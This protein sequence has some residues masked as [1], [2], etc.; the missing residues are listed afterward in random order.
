[1]HMNKSLL[2]TLAMLLTAA[3]GAWADAGYTG[4]K[5]TFTRADAGSGTATDAVSD[6]TVNVTDKD[7]NAIAGVSATLASTTITQL[8]TG[9][10]AALSRTSNA[11]LAPNAGYANN[12]NSTIEYTFCVT[13]LSTEFTYNYAALDVY[14]LTSGGAAQGNTGNTVREWTFDVLTGSTS[15]GVSSFVSQAGN[16]ICTVTNSDG[17]LYHKTWEMAAS[18]ENATAT[19]YIKV[20]LKKTDSNGCYAGLGSVQL[21]Y[22][23]PAVVISDLNNLS[24]AKSYSLS[25]PRGTLGVNGSTFVSTAKDFTASEFA[26]VSYGGAYY[27]YSVAAKKFVT[28]EGALAYTVT[29]SSALT[30]EDLGSSN[31]KLKLG[32]SNYINVS[33]G[34]DAGLVVDAHSTTDEGNTFTITEASDFDATDAL[35]AL[36]WVEYDEENAAGEIAY[37]AGLGTYTKTNG[38]AYASEWVSNITA[39]QLTLLTDVN[40]IVIADGGLHTQTYKLS[41]PAGYRITGYSFTATPS[42][43]TTGMS[44]TPAGSSA[45][46][47]PAGGTAVDVTGLNAQTT[48]FD[49]SG[50]YVRVSNFKVTYTIATIAYITDLASL[51]NGKAYIVTNA[52][53]A[54]QVASASATAFS[55]NASVNPKTDRGNTALQIAIIKQGE[56]YYLYSVNAGKYLTAANSLYASPLDSVTI[57]EAT[58]TGAPD[59]HKWFFSFDSSHNINVNS[60]PDFGTGTWSTKDA[61]NVCAII[62]AADFDN[63]AALAAFTNYGQRVAD[64]ATYK[65]YMTDF[66]HSYQ[67]EIGYP[68]TTSTGYTN[69]AS[70]LTEAS[71]FTEDDYNNLPTYYAA[72]LAETDINTPSAGFYRIYHAVTSGGTKKYLTDTGSA[73]VMPRN[74]YSIGMEALWLLI[75]EDITLIK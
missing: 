31:F 35:A 53:A 4:I 39:P 17:G 74:L 29:S 67:S 70:I 34:Y 58:Y 56:A 40:N 33:S 64:Y 6:V 13:G 8:K 46:N 2:V 27:L 3:S 52:R 25:T 24:N 41:V 19:L 26:I 75:M 71:V 49:V 14:A 44:V 5:L 32:S 63:T 15:D 20:V 22:V 1:M 61:G 48:T 55:A 42:T 59:N 65:G 66:V 21:Y 12:Q 38:G 23:A 43:G 57:T 37:S 9:S 69:L 30:F 10:A 72:Y 47:I 50:A 62:E 11:V 28:S 51:E 7:G 45:I 36:K 60:V 18:N 16:D 68:K 73:L 54:W